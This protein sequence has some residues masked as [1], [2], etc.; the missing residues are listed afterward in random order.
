MGRP[1][2][3]ERV[4]GPEWGAGQCRICWLARYDERYLLLWGGDSSPR[5]PPRPECVNFSEV[6]TDHRAPDGAE[7]NCPA[8]KLYFCDLYGKCARTAAAARPGVPC[9]EAC[10]SHEPA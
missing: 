7:C 6:V 5:P 9:C 4:T 2:F 1:C 10:E 3:C 8:R